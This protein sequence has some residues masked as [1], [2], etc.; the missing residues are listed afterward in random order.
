MNV[1]AEKAATAHGYWLDINLPESDSHE[2]EV[3][4]FIS[5]IVGKMKNKKKLCQRGSKTKNI[6]EDTQ[7]QI[8]NTIKSNNI[9]EGIF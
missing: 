7:K 4:G 1:E 5:E 9:S 3:E 6:N 2:E 8:N